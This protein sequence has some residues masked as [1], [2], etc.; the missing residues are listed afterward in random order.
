MQ[1]KPGSS[2]D[3]NQKWDYMHHDQKFKIGGVKTNFV[4]NFLF[5]LLARTA[6]FSKL[7]EP[8]VMDGFNITSYQL[9]R[10]AQPNTV[11]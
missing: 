7:N 8:Y 10:P 5:V 4:C 2:E 9:S 3:S 1:E 11:G 6:P